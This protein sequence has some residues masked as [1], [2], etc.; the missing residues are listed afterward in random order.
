MRTFHS[1]KFPPPQEN[2]YPPQYLAGY[3]LISDTELIDPNFYRTVVLILSHDENGALGLVIN[4]P[5]ATTIA[6]LS[7]DELSDSPFVEHT[8]NVGGPVDQNY[9]FALHT[10]LL[11]NYK[12]ESSIESVPGI[13]FEP[14][15]S[16]LQR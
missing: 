14:D 16:L 8:V 15:F 5:S 1:Y 4:R 3:F 6:D 7:T 13:V 11:D 10:G 12:S 2:D 9:L